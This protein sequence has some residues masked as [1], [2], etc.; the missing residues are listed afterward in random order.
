MT[1]VGMDVVPNHVGGQKNAQQ[2]I[3]PYDIIENSPT[4][5]ANNSVFI[6]PNNFKFGTKTLYM[7]V[8]DILVGKRMLSNLFSHMT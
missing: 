6:G 1:K 2:P 8:Y 3:F 7:V 5:F 4:S